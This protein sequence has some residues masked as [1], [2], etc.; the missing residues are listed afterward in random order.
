MASLA[1]IE[2][3]GPAFAAKLKEAGITAQEKFL[4]AGSTPKGRKEL[5][6]K[7]GISDKL[8]LEW[9]NHCD[10]IRIKGVGGEY[11]DLLEE[12]G[13]DTIPELA[14]RKPENLL[15]KMT[16]VN[17]AKKIVRKLPVLKQVEDWV[18]QAKDLPRVIKY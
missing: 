7:T 11:S 17:A 18:K 6:D 14:N 3:I 2:G 9:V 1:E 8:I 10:L 13:V 16:E 4:E 5:G 15:A 12:A